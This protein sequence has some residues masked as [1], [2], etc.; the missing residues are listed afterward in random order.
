M[1][2]NS[3]LVIIPGIMW[4][5]VTVMFNL[6]ND[7]NN[8]IMTKSAKIWKKNNTS[9]IYWN[10]NVV[11]YFCYI[12]CKTLCNYIVVFKKCYVP[13]TGLKTY[14]K[15]IKDFLLLLL[16]FTNKGVGRNKRVIKSDISASVSNRNSNKFP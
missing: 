3:N 13:E 8:E 15:F 14:Y 1:N 6:N 9:I 2:C 12:L 5:S 16:L 10:K 11:R 7:N 4:R